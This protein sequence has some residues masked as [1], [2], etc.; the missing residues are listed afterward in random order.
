MRNEENSETGNE[1][2]KELNETEKRG[3]FTDVF[4]TETDHQGKRYLATWVYSVFLLI[5]LFVSILAIPALSKKPEVY[6]PVKNIKLELEGRSTVQ[7]SVS[8][9][10]IENIEISQPKGENAIAKTEAIS[11]SNGTGQSLNST[12]TTKSQLIPRPRATMVLEQQN[13]NGKQDKGGYAD[14]ERGIREETSLNSQ[15]RTEG[16]N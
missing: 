8:Y 2:P 14:D 11:K 10:G 12:C 3:K 6:S 16:A 5:A 15:E 7:V 1:N 13:Q 4:L 9:A